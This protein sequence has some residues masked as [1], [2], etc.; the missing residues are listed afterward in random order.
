MEG[1]IEAIRQLICHSER[2]EKSRPLAIA[3]GDKIDNQE[4]WRVETREIY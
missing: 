3:Q 2:S 1:D 4:V